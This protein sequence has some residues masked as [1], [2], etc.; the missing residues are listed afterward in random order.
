MSNLH[1]VTGYAGKAHITAA[2]HGAFHA[3]IYGDGDYVLDG[4][5]DQF[6][7]YISGTNSVRVKSGH[8]LMQGRHAYSSTFTD[9]TLTSGSVGLQRHDLI[10]A[11]YTIDSASGVED[12]SLVV[13]TGTASSSPADPAIGTKNILNDVFA[14][15]D[16]HDF[17]LY[18]VV[19][20]GTNMTKLVP[21]FEELHTP[22]WYA[23]RIQ[24]ALDDINDIAD[25]IPTI[26]TGTASIRY[27]NY[28]ESEVA[29][30][31][32]LPFAEKPVVLTTQIF[33]SHPIIV[34]EEDISTTGFTAR[35][36]VVEG[37]GGSDEAATYRDF[38]WVAISR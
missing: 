19:W 22:D 25:S 21:L 2:D 10:V 30:T 35:V 16:S 3:A 9:L 4:H 38:S 27:R 33:E 5:G 14:D 8:L 29:V 28:K 13:V 18:R 34:K 24:Q 1:L 26:Q 11:R 37:G 31:F 36:G 17:P 12:C 23:D 15:G 32:A 7:A 20:S 6:S